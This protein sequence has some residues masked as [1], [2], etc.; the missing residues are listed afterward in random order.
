MTYF[1]L[2]SAGYLLGLIWMREPVVTVN[3][4]FKYTVFSSFLVFSYRLLFYL[5]SRKELFDGGFPSEFI[6]ISLHSILCGLSI[7]SGLLLSKIL[8]LKSTMDRFS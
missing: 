8:K 6:D 4:F 7:S 2:L 1:I 3:Q 5:V